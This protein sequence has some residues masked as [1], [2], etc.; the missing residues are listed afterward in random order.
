MVALA[1]D[2]ALVGAIGD[3]VGVAKQ[4]KLEE[5]GLANLV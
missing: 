3:E 1:D 5:L 4:K 2:M